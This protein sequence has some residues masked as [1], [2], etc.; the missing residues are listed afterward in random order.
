[1][2]IMK[3]DERQIFDRIN[4]I[5]KIGIETGRMTDWAVKEHKERKNRDPSS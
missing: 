4:G 2:R 1:M 3:A 5:N